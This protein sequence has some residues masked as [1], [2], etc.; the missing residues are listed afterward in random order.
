MTQFREKC[1]EWP[2][3]KATMRAGDARSLSTPDGTVDLVFTSPPYATA[4]DYPRAHFLAV[5]WMQEAL[6][7]SLDEYK[8]KA[9]SYIGSERGSLPRELIVDSR[10][11]RFD[12]TVSVINSLAERSPRHAVLTM[13]YFVDMY[14]AFS[15][16]HRVLKRQ[17]HAIIVVCPSHIRKLDIPT[18]KIFAE[19]G[20]ALGLKLK[21][22]YQR[23]INERLRL[24]PYMQESF[25][26]RMSTEYVLIFQ[27]QGKN[28]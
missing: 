26:K 22:E 27:K 1:Q 25:G 20:R 16:M 12:L 9:S 3:T 5:A 13:R 7:I 28:E 14:R 23:T 18:H 4:L 10:L 8:S 6:G 19:M 15:E 24:L 2:G 11:Q 17:R 21:Y